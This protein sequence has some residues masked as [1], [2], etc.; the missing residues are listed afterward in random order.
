MKTFVD[1]EPANVSI[2]IIPLVDVV[3][4]V[5]TFFILAA[6]G[7]TRVQGIGINLPR[8]E[9][10]Q[11]QFGDKLSLQ[12]NAVGQIFV[13]NDPVTQAD[14][15]NRLTDYRRGNPTG[16][17]VI[18][19][20]RQASYEK[21]VQVLDLLQALGVNRVALG[22]VDQDPLAPVDPLNLQPVPQPAP[23]QPNVNPL[24]VPPA[25][26]PSLPP[27]PSADPNLPTSPGGNGTNPSGAN[28]NGTNLPVAPGTPPLNTSP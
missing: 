19:A 11:S 3:F 22:S 20:D 17:V 12:V 10:S 24:G 18:D 6:V 1:N 2:E 9:S 27:V 23:A 8:T 4:C 16:L 13:N 25:G 7:L 28:P 14:L 26:Q 5:L 21:V 15:V